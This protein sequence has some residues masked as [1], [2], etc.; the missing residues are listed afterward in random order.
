MFVVD[1]DRGET[2]CSGCG[3]VLQSAEMVPYANINPVSFGAR[4]TRADIPGNKMMQR[5]NRQCGM[6]GNTVNTHFSIMECRGKLGLPLSIGIRAVA[7]FT[8]LR[9]AMK[10]RL[11]IKE[12]A[13]AS[14]Y[15]A[16]RES[17][18]TRTLDE[19]CDAMNSN[20]KRTWR[21]YGNMHEIVKSAPPLVSPVGFVTRLTS[22]LGLSMKVSR[23]A[24]DVWESMRD[25]KT[26]QRE[27]RLLV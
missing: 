22:N 25:D 16:C 26:D 17:S 9:A 11:G 15:M 13:A 5:L 19:I 18:V 6:D 14:V 1:P 3:T 24:L 20:K 7:L 21:F 23:Q 27:T 12:M 10:G 2:V 4:G 8:K